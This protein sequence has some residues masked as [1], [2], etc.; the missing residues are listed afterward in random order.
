M[1]QSR[2]RQG[3][4]GQCTRTW[5]GSL[6]SAAR[7][8]EEPWQLQVV[9]GGGG[10]APDSSSLC[11][12][13]AGGAGPGRVVATRPLSAAYPVVPPLPPSIAE[14]KTLGPRPAQ[15][16]RVDSSLLPPLPRGQGHRVMLL[17]MLSLLLLLLRWLAFHR[18]PPKLLSGQ[19]HSI[20]KQHTVS[21]FLLACNPEGMG[22]A[23]EIA[24]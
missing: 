24:G 14:L 8:L 10:T 12:P 20:S 13:P 15:G 19:A 9:S 5:R 2:R 3:S 11:A 7:R 6:T 1:R 4:R 22:W 18:E 23:G 16:F 21:S 17:T